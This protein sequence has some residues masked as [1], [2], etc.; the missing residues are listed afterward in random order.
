MAAAAKSLQS[1]QTLCDPIDSSPAG[2]PSPG[3][4]QARTLEWV[5]ISFSSAWKGKVKVK[6]LS[7]VQLLATPWTAAHQAP[8]S[9]GFSRQEDCSGGPLPSPTRMAAK[10]N[11]FG[12]SSMRPCYPDSPGT[13]L[14]WSQYL[15]SIMGLKWRRQWQ[16]IPVL[17]PGKSHG[18][19]RGRLGGCHLRGRTELDTTA[20]TAAAVWT[21]KGFPGGTSGKK[22]SCQC[23]RQ[24]SPVQSLWQGDPPEWRQGNPLQCS[25]LENP[26]DRGAW[27]ATVHRVSKSETWLKQFSTHAHMDLKLLFCFLGKRNPS[28]RFDN[29]LID[30]GIFIIQNGLSTKFP[31]TYSNCLFDIYFPLAHYIY[32][33]KYT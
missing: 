25:C 16:P 21:W 12:W 22:P 13:S 10:N 9:M 23:R 27:R 31:P 17:L 6:L 4:L 11:S 5:A 30:P 18:H 3:I 20:V 33:T 2:S 19:G 24:E 26:M 32:Q 15:T 29:T 14:F 7:G 28:H 1:C 8:P